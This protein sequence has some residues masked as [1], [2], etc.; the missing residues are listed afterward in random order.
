[1]P[2]KSVETVPC[3]AGDQYHSRVLGSGELTRDAYARALVLIVTVSVAWRAWVVSR[4][5]WQDDDWVYLGNIE[6]MSTG[7]YLFQMYNGHL[8]PGE[9]LVME[10]IT[11]IAPLNYAL[12]ITLTALA[13]GGVVILWAWAFSA[14]AGR[15]WWTLAPLTLIAMSPLL[16]RPTMWWA[17]ALQV[18]PLQACLAWGVLVAARQAK[19]PTAHAWVHLA[20]P[21]VVSLVFWEKGLLLAL[22]LALTLL[23][24]YGGRPLPRARTHWRSLTMLTLTAVAYT[25]A[26]LALGRLGDDQRERG[27]NFSDPPTPGESLEFYWSGLGNLLGPALLGGPWG[28]LPTSDDFFSTAPHWVAVPSAIVLAVGVVLTLSTRRGSGVILLA[29]IAYTVVAWALVLFSS[30]FVN[31]GM[32]AINDE[33]Y[34][35]DCFS[36]WL[37]GGVLAWSGPRTRDTSMRPLPRLPVYGAL[38]G[39]VGSLIVANTWAV[40]RIGPS[41]ATSWLSTLRSEID[42]T[43]VAAANNEPLVLVDRFAPD[44]VMAWA[45]WAD[46]SRL[47]FMLGPL[48]PQVDFFRA[49]AELWAVMDDGTL[50]RVDVDTAVEA[51]PG[52]VAD[53]G[54][55]IPPGGDVEV[56]LTS[57]LYFWNWG[58][59]MSAYSSEAASLTLSIGETSIPVKLAG[60]PHTR[61]AQYD[62]EVGDTIV[63]SSAPGSGTVCVTDLVIGPLDVESDGR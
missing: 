34:S 18:L 37:L 62:G 59:K 58:V 25:L 36:V 9:F 55:V 4:W 52:P 54:Y 49:S 14:L 31:L 42:S 38:A 33:R 10:L 3:A 7:D 60:G 45:Y 21:Y 8:M 47:S 16:V 40:A 51:R 23:T 39:T 41:P 11:A 46:K 19:Q 57:G 43:Q 28:T 35:V 53:C 63:I 27:I 30:R 5:N 29:T 56:P 26:Y 6:L 32:I 12:P 13:S 61:M 44:R 20:I 50:E 1:M 48:A 24:A 2:S 22:P 15:R 17:S